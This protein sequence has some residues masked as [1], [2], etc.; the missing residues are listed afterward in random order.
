MARGG[1]GSAALAVLSGAGILAWPKW[2]LREGAV[3]SFFGGLSQQ[4]HFTQ[5]P[6]LFQ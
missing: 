4:H 6:A 2:G 5:G 3:A 1:Y